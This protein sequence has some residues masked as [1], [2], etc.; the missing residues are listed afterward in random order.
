MTLLTLSRFCSRHRWAVLG[1]WLV[2]LVGGVVAAPAV[3]DG[4][5]TQA[6][7]VESSE[8][9]QVARE[10]SR[11]DP[12][13]GELVAVADGRSV[14]DAALQRSVAD[15]AARL[16]ATP[17]ID[18]VRTPWTDD[19]PRLVAQDRRAVAV[20]VSLEGNLPPAVHEA[21]LDAAERGLRSIDAPRVLV[22]SEDLRD[23][24]FEDQ[25]A[26]D[27]ERAELLSM[28]VA[29]VVLLVI[30][31]GIVAAGLPVVVALVGV[32]ATLLS[33]LAFSAISDV[34][35]FA[36]NVM[37]MLG[38]GLAVDYALLVVYRF[39]EERATDPDV[40][41]ALDRTMTSAGCTVLFSGL[42]VA[43]SLAGLL[44]FDDVFL[45]SMGYAGMSV[46]V[47]DMLAA[48][49]LLPALLSLV[50]HRIRPARPRPA[51]RGVFVRVAR[52][53]ARRPVLVA[54]GVAA[55]LALAAAPFL[56]ARFASPDARSLPTSSEARQ[57]HDLGTSRFAAGADREPIVVLA[58]GRPPVSYVNRVE[59]LA[60]VTD[61]VA[62]DLPD[63]RVAIDVYAEG[64]TE[65]PRAQSVV[66]AIRDLDA[67][68]RTRVTGDAAEAV[69]Y[70]DSIRDRLP[71]SLAII[72]LS[73]GVLLFMFTGSVVVPVKALLMNTLSLGATFGALVWVFQDGHLGGLVGTEALGALAVETPV[74]VFAIAFGL[75]MDYEVFLLSRIQ[76]A[77]R[78][79]GHNDGAVREGLQRT[80]AI[81][82]SAALLIA[83]VF[84]GF[85]AGGFSP[86]K[87]VGLGLLVAVVVDATLVRMLLVPA[88]MR[89]MGRWNWWA[90]APLRR[91]H[92]RVSL[93]EPATAPV[94]EEREPA[95][96][97]S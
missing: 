28:P 89:L 27:L 69:D 65:G 73:T 26:A 61:V 60:D 76:E 6:G 33:L 23:A 22:T 55:L 15:V 1:T 50:G 5:S 51:D 77:Y 58:D 72:V 68:V 18:E 74:L 53:S 56:G 94:V 91:L 13:G 4:L 47:L 44:V 64:P 86:V 14:D 12:D 8:S 97:R 96:S 88:A 20:L 85:V 83:I 66:R 10:L 21:A 46:V 29:L 81:V 36:V 48:L 45:R 92:D 59:S 70:L 67:P 11:V 82:T 43:A 16:A 78:R 95:L 52:V 54:A 42:T 41:G 63:G 25:A 84:A 7:Y 9:A 57:L 49:T 31:G 93:H 34:S 17:G 75:S 71:W 80:G 62:R 2:V 32:S 30:F 38:L 35:V 79:T 39:R 24:E 40:G 3:F 87:Q 19:D 37:T 90:P